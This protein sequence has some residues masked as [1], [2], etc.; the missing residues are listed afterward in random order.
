MGAQG[1]FGQAL[2]VG[3]AGA[4]GEH[5]ADEAAHLFL[6]P[7]PGA[8]RA[9][10]AGGDGGRV[11]ADGIV[12]QDEAGDEAVAVFGDVGQAVEDA[13]RPADE[14]DGAVA[15]GGD[16]FGDVLAA[17]LIGVARGGDLALALA[18]GI[19]REDVVA[20]RESV[21]LLLEDPGR[22]GPAGDE[23][24]RVARG[25]AGFDN[26]Q[27]DVVSRG[28]GEIARGRGCGSSEQRSQDETEQNEPH[29]RL[30]AGLRCSLSTVGAR[31]HAFLRCLWRM[32]VDDG[33][34]PGR[35]RQLIASVLVIAVLLAVGLWLTGALRSGS[36]IQDCVAAGRTNCAPIAQ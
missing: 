22:H 1:V 30:M 12:D 4:A 36:A 32:S 29:A 19:K 2:E 9:G 11:L 15:V 10:H 6:A 23:H 21:E 17:T 27:A 25:I 18:A 20:G 34:D 28:E 33:E 13:E 24:D 5:A 16:Q 26:V 7:Q 35:K 3:L 8:A 14:H 31:V